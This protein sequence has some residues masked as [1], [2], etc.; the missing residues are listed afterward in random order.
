FGPKHL[1]LRRAQAEKMPF[2]AHR[3][4]TIP[5][6]GG[7]ASRAVVAIRV[8]GRTR[9]IMFLDFFPRVRVQAIDEIRFL[10]IPH[11]VEPAIDDRA[12]GV[13]HSNISLP[14]FLGWRGPLRRPAGLLRN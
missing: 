11:R 13:T 6:P 4:N 1:S 3:G 10:Q 5:I 9:I 7:S 2:T 12:R 8:L 14:D